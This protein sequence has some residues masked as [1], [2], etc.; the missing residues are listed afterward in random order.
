MA[1]AEIF[2]NDASP[3]PEVAPD[4]PRPLTPVISVGISDLTDKEK[5]DED[6]MGRCHKEGVQIDIDLEQRDA[7][8][9]EVDVKDVDIEEEKQKS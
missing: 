9:P 6:T 5:I 1:L 3:E 7:F 4:A 8:E 2:P